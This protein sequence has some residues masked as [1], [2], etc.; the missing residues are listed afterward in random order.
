MGVT[1]DLSFRR[2]AF[3]R[4]GAKAGGCLALVALAAAGITLAYTPIPT[5]HNDFF[6]PGT[7]PNS[8]VD[9]LITTQTC[10]YCH[11]DYDEAAAPWNRWSA[12]MMGQSARDPIFRAAL[13]IA[14]Q[15]ATNSGE[16][17]L[18]CHAPQ[19]WLNGRSTPSNG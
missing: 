2:R 4:L 19:G 7:Q 5:T 15:D 9:P 12:S 16:T 13:A 1:S 14:E 11:S 8:L 3:A 17:C 10:A 6:V 18:R